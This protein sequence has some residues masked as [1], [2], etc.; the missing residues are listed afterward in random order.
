LDIET[1][2]IT[3]KVQQDEIEVFA[4][5][6]FEKVF[7]L[8]FDFANR[9]GE[10]VTRIDIS[11]SFT[12]EGLIIVVSDN[13]IGIVPETKG[14]IFEWRPGND[15]NAGLHL[16]QKILSN[17]G[18]SIRENGEFKKGARFEIIVPKDAFHTEPS[19]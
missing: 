1:D 13:G 10:K 6:L 3:L 16:A 2:S 8:L 12:P 9:Y 19:Q 5:P 7:Y 4:D 14:Q 17:T 15:K 11:Y 18:L